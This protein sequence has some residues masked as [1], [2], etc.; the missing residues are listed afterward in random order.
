MKQPALLQ[1]TLPVVRPEDRERLEPFV[2]VFDR[3]VV[4]TA[5]HAGFRKAGRRSLTKLT[6]AIEATIS[7]ELGHASELVIVLFAFRRCGQVYAAAID[8]TVPASI[9]RAQFHL[10][11]CAWRLIIELEQFNRIDDLLILT[12]SL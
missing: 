9:Q 5:R 10:I 12:R 3:V 11:D 8:Q 2:S 4:T 6:T 7:D 1:V